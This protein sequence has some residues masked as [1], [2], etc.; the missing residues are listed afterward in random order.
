LAH[1]DLGSFILAQTRDSVLAAP[2]HL[3]TWGILAAHQALASPSTAAEAKVRALHVSY[4]VECRSQPA[5]IDGAGLEADLRRGR[6][7]NW[8]QSLSTPGQTLRIYRVRPFSLA[9]AR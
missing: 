4:V 3:M 7:P 2:Y 5:W 9:A 1:I 8:L 6:T